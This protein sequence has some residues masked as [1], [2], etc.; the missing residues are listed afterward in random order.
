MRNASIA[1]ALRTTA[2]GPLFAWGAS[3]ESLWLPTVAAASFGAGVYLFYVMRG[4]LVAFVD[5]AIAVDSS[6]TVHA[7]VAEQHGSDPLLR[8]VAAALSLCALVGLLLG[9]AIVL[10]GLVAPL[11]EGSTVLAAALVS[12]TLASVVLCA[13]LSGHAG[14]MHSAQLQLGMLYLGLFGAA[15]LVLYMHASARAPMPPHGALALVALVACG[16]IVLVYRRSKYVDTDPIRSGISG[17]DRPSRGAR[18]LSRFEKILNVVLSILLAVM[19]VVALLDINAAGWTMVASGGM[20]AL[21][22]PTRLPTVAPLA[23]VVMPLFYPLVDVTNWLRVAALRTDADPAVDP[24]R[25]SA[26]LKSALRIYAVER[27]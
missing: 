23:L 22:S 13:V 24:R 17:S 19:I 6:I 2:L 10:A 16:A 12:T 25:R 4:R 27:R 11:V 18:A 15:A 3:G 1:Y 20:A 8:R 7:F 5:S 9:E 21:R 14:I 26:A